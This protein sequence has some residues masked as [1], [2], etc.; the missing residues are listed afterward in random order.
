MLS[1]WKVRPDEIPVVD[2]LDNGLCALGWC[3]SSPYSTFN[4]TVESHLKHYFRKFLLKYFCV[5]LMKLVKLKLH[6]F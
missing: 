3:V 2:F 6:T 5:G 4:Q 1:A